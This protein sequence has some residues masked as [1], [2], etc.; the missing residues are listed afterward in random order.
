MKKLVALALAGV[1]LLA[2]PA[3]AADIKHA[4][5]AQKGVLGPTLQ[6]PNDIGPGTRLAPEL[7]ARGP[8]LLGFEGNT[9]YDNALLGRNSIP[10]DTM[11]AVGGTQY[12]VTTNGSYGVYDK[13]TGARQSLVS[14][15][16]FWAAAGQ[17]GASGDTRIMYNADAQRWLMVSFGGNV[18]DLQIAVS[19]TDDALGAWQSVKF[20]GYAGLGFGG[21]ADYP[22]LAMDRNAVYIGTNNFARSTANGTD[23]FRGTTLDV[24]PLSSLFSADAPTLAG[25]KMF[26]TPFSAN[27]QED[28][29]FAIQGVNS[30]DVKSSGKAVAASLFNYDSM[31]YSIDG[32][33]ATSA[34]G[35][36][37]GAVDYVGEAA[38]TTAGAGRQ[39][40]TIAAN[41]R[42]IDTLDERISSSV[43]EVNGRIYYLHTANST[44][45]GVD[46]AR[47]RVAVLDSATNDI[48]DQFDIG[49]GAFDFYQGAIAVNKSG[50]VVIGYNR[51]GLD[52]TDGVIGFYGR[53]FNT[54]ADG[55]LI[56]TSGELLLKQSLT[57][58]YH[59]GSVFGQAAAGRQRWGDY[60]QV[61]VD[62]TNDK[63]FYLIGQFAREYNLPQFGHPGGTGGS[64]WST[65][66]SVI[67]V[68]APVPEP[69]TWAMMIAG[70]GFVG[71][72]VR[73]SR[74]RTSVTYA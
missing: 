50:Q 17:T 14:D 59:N 51:S 45:D 26:E 28:R 44:A 55:K 23:T 15:V 47:I 25:M 39:P 73:Q 41:Q 31:A 24:I 53:S 60:A 30:S 34:T 5:W 66:V 35:A 40:A 1:S 69:G 64:R 52:P 54:G 21:I 46:Y 11:G 58:D 72:A 71:G 8:V 61:S 68:E 13:Y 19:R 10:P 18:K 4:W 63:N 20:E 62:P 32:L 49:E 42:I 74:R 56:A 2:V 29:G 7:T 38:F 12:M 27:Q 36:T 67:N 33:T 9:Q 65:W 6:V 70:F 22:T 37:L 48:L 57:N 16:A 3:S 43:Y